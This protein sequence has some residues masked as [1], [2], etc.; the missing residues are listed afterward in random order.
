[1]TLE[2]V[3]LVYI[4]GEVY[5]KEKRIANNFKLHSFFIRSNI[6]VIILKYIIS[7]IW[8]EQMRMVMLRAKLFIVKGDN[9]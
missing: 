6:C 4:L 2:D 9:I 7:Y 3:L 8:K 5:S 1:M